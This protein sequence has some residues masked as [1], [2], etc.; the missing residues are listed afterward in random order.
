MSDIRLF[1]D[2]D[3]TLLLYDDEGS[4]TAHHYGFWRGDAFHINEPLVAFMRRFREKHEDALIVIWSGGGANYAHEVM[5]RVGLGEGDDDFIDPIPMIKDRTT[6]Y[7]VREGDIV[8]DDQAIE[9]P[10]TVTPPDFF[11]EGGIAWG[12]PPKEA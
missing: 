3:S 2:C 8:V 6:F 9:V 12:I 11:D 5:I 7:L 10:T 4:P 1:V